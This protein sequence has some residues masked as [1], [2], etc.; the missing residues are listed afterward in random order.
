MSKRRSRG[1]PEYTALSRRQFVAAGLAALGA[2]AWLPRVAFGEGGDGDRDVLISIYLRGGA[3]GLTLCVPHAEDAYYQARP[4]LSVPRPDSGENGAATDLDGFF[5]LPSPMTPLME[6]YEAG[7]ALFVHACGS[8]DETRSH[9]DAQRYM[10]TGKPRDPRLATGWL[11][12]HLLNIAASDPQPVLRALAIGGALP[13]TLRGGPLTLPVPD[14]GGFSI[15]GNPG[16]V[17]ERVDTLTDLYANAAEPLKTAAENTKAVIDLLDAIDFEGYQP[18]NGAVYPDTDFGQALRA[19]AALLKAEAGVE[20]IAVDLDGWDT[21]DAQGSV[22]GYMATLMDELARTLAACYADLIAGGEHRV[23]VVVMTEFGRVVAQNGNVGT[24]HGHGA[25]MILL[26]SHIAGGQVLADWP[27]L[28]PA[29]LYEGQDLEV[30]IDYR[31]ILAEVL[32]NRLAATALDVIF[33]DYT[34]VLRGVT[35]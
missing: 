35:V 4:G 33:P 10:E 25:A 11:G 3:D 29:Q 32:Q 24:D 19:T 16:T 7:H 6:A 13:L 23:T 21:H 15:Y 30:T 12:R 31:D 5:G 9:F 14:P 26:G 17:D 28:G 20:A 1:C 27:G 18:A 2:P 34:P 8:S 22:G